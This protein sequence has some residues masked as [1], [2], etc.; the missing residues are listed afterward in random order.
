MGV[1]TKAGSGV[2]LGH[3]YQA[4]TGAAG[5]AITHGVGRITGARPLAIPCAFAHSIGTAASIIL[6]AR[7][8]EFTGPDAIPTVT[9]T[10]AAGDLLGACGDTVGVHVAAPVVDETVVDF[11]A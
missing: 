3:H 4:D 6:G 7:V 11:L 2:Q 9:L 1:I 8:Q 10:A 5:E